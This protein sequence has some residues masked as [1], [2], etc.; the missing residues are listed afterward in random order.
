MILLSDPAV[1]G[2]AKEVHKGNRRG[3]EAGVS[4]AP[5]IPKENPF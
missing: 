5:K 1:E 4:P 3:E 2:R